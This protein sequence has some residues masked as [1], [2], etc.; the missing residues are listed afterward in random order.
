[1]Y[2]G[3]V[4]LRRGD[5]GV[6][7]GVLDR[8]AGFLGEGVGGEDEAASRWQH[9][10]ADA[11]EAEVPVDE[12]ARRERAEGVRD[13]GLERDQR[14][15]ADVTGP[16][17]RAGAGVGAAGVGEHGAQALALVHRDHGEAA[18]R[19]R[20]GVK[21]DHECSRAAATKRAYMSS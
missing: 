7:R 3:E 11:V 18:G 12:E 17:A 15:V 4:E 16:G 1:V 20:D 2:A 14:V 9:A 8:P 13:R 5:G 21:C 19:A 10:V 6:D